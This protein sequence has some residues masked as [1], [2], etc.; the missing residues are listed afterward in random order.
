MGP[1]RGSAEPS[2]HWHWVLGSLLPLGAGD[3]GDYCLFYLCFLV[4]WGTSV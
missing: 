1:Q 2:K 4:L 3:V